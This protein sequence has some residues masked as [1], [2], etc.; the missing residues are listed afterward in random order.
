M[1][2]ALQALLAL[3]DGEQGQALIMGVGVIAIGLGAVMIS[4]DVGWWVRDRGD[5]QNDAD[6]I[7]LAAAGEL[8]DATA[9][10]ASAFDAADAN[11]IDPTTEIVQAPC[12]DG[13]LWGNLCLVDRNNDS[14]VDGVRVRL[15]R[16]SNSFLASAFGVPDPQITVSAVAG[17][18]TVNGACLK[19][20]A[21]RAVSE[22]PLDPT[23]PFGLDEDERYVLKDKPTNNPGDFGAITWYGRD[24]DSYRDAIKKDCGH[25]EVK[26]NACTTDGQLL[27]REGDFLTECHGRQEQAKHATNA[28]DDRYDNPG[29]CD[30]ASAAEAAQMA[31]RSRCADRAVTVGITSDLP[32]DDKSHRGGDAKVDVTVYGIAT[33]YIAGWANNDKDCAGDG[34]DDDDDREDCVWGYLIPHTPALPQ[35][36]VSW[37]TPDS[38]SSN[39][40]TPIGVALVE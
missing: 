24:T 4:L 15:S 6:A 25:F 3:V 17:D 9:A 27:V 37:S 5:L 13:S 38:P 35:W 10:E 22:N 29:R 26:E 30:V 1:L 19:P 40:L 14:H 34:N 18:L 7:A 12:D 28:L 36:L 31:S 2:R 20:W 39:P 8:Q 23:G 33:F 21:I 16:K 32:L 11:G